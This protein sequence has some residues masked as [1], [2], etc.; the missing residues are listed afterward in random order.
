MYLL[1]NQDVDLTFKG[2]DA[3]HLIDLLCCKLENPTC[4][5]EIIIQA[6]YIF[7]NIAIGNSQH[8]TMIMSSRCLANI[9]RFIDHTNHLVRT[10]AIWCVINLTWLEDEGSKDRIKTLRGHLI[11][12]RLEHLM[13][14]DD[15][16]DVRDRSSTALS[17]LKGDY[18]CSDVN[19]SNG[20][21][22]LNL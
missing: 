2:I 10:A 12:E 5:Q 16:V 6:L 11:Y 1:L 8:K 18:S 14:H 22:R 21:L 20:D 19:M 7:V 4:T 9:C 3:H 15:N 17:N 13:H